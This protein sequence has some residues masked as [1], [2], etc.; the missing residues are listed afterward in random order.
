MWT[1]LQA[2]NWYDNVVVRNDNSFVTFFDSISQTKPT[3]TIVKNICRQHYMDDFLER[4]Q[5]FEVAFNNIFIYVIRYAG[6]GFENYELYAYDPRSNRLSEK[7]FEL[8]GK[9]SADNESG[10][11]KP[12][13]EG[14]M[15]EITGEKLFLKERVHNGNSYNAVLLYVLRCNIQ[16][17]FELLY[18]VEECALLNMPEMSSDDILV[19]RRK[20]NENLKVNCYKES[21][22]E[23]KQIIGCFSLSEDGIVSEIEI[24]DSTYKRW[25]VTVSGVD[26]LFFSKKG[27][28][29]GNDGWDRETDSVPTEKAQ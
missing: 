18:C 28:N 29:N 24:F 27:Y 7:P 5:I 14:K 19:I 21:A 3:P 17:E 2:S 23:E 11:S 1:P 20:I 6:I 22:N 12:I 9:W 4:N 10:F 26:F 16:L 25:I 8:S 13:L 15:M